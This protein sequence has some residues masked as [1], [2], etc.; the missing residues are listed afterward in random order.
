M[1]A[2]PCK[3]RVGKRDPTVRTTAQDV[4]WRWLAV[5]AEEKPRL[6]IHV[7]VTPAIE[8]DAG[9]VSARIEPAGREHVGELL[10]ERAL[11]LR[12]R[13]A[14]QPRASPAPRPG[15]REVWLGVEDPDGQHRRSARADGPAPECRARHRPCP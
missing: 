13:G 9:N 3:I 7:R 15:D 12:E 8:N 1:I 5:A 14:E 6:R 2:G 4:P 11:V 10:A